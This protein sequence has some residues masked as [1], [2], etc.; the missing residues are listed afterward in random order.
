[1]GKYSSVSFKTP[2]NMITFTYSYFMRPWRH[3]LFKICQIF[4]V[5]IVCLSIVAGWTVNNRSV[6]L[7]SFFS[8]RIRLFISWHTQTGGYQN[9]FFNYTTYTSCK[10]KWSFWS[11]VIDRCWIDLPLNLSVSLQIHFTGGVLDCLLDVVGVF[12]GWG[13]FWWEYREWKNIS[14]FKLSNIIIFLYWLLNIIWF[15]TCKPLITTSNYH[16]H[17]TSSVRLYAFL[18]ILLSV[19]I[20]KYSLKLCQISVIMRIKL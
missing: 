20:L 14:C 7:Y 10:C 9:W 16:E 12:G 8:Q 2:W 4:F 1:M 17:C 15:V 3:W 11:R 6:A 18:C 13:S 5:S 19:I